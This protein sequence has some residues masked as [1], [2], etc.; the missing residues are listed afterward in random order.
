MVF[1]TKMKVVI[2]LKKL[3]TAI[4][5]KMTFIKKLQLP[6]R[7]DGWHSLEKKG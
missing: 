3:L 7:S 5:S 4:L 2:G 1:K 6:V